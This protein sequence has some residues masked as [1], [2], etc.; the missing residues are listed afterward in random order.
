MKTFAILLT[1]AAV[2][3]AR[4]VPARAQPQQPVRTVS[5]FFRD[6]TAEWMRA[7]P[8]Q[9]AATRY[10]T[11][12]EQDRFEE[13]IA[14]NTPESRRAVIL[15]ARKGLAELATFDRGRM[16]ETERTSADLMQWQLETLVE[17]EKYRDYQFPLEQFGGANVNLPA[18]LTVNHP[19]VTEKDAVH[20]VSRLGQVGARMDEAVAEASG[21]IAKNMIPPRF[22]L[23]ATIVQ[24]RQFIATPPSKNPFVTA[25][26]DRLATAKAV[27]D[28]RREELREQAERIVATQVYPAWKRGIAV[29]EP[30]VGRAKDD[31]GL[32]RFAGGSDAYA[33][34]LRRFTT[35]NLTADEIHKIGL[36]RVAAIEQQMEAILKQLGRTE[37]TLKD[38]IK[39]I[40]KSQAYPLTEEGRRLIMADVERILRD[41]ERRA[42]LQF[43]VRPKAP[44]VAQ[45]YPRFREANAAASYSA[46]APDGS[47]PGTFQIP[48]R[49]ER[50]TK[51][52]LRT[53]VYHETVPGHHF[54]VALEMENPSLPRFRRVRAFGG[55]SAL[56]EGWGLYA[57]RL[58]AE[59]GWYDN[60]LEGQL[61]QLDM[62]L[63]RA[64]RLVVDTGIHAK[65]W[66]RQQAIDYGIEASEVERYVVNPG[67]ACSYMMGELK[68]LELRDKAKKALGDKFS[69]RDFHTAVLSAGTV[70]LELLERRV[71]A[72]LR[73]AAVVSSLPKGES[74]VPVFHEPHHRMLFAAGTTKILEG[75]LPPGDT[76]W[77]HVHTEP[78]LYITLS[79]SQQRTQVL[80]QEM[81][82]GRGAPPAVGRANAPPAPG[83]GGA[84]PNG[85]AIRATSTTSYYDEPVTH[86]ITNVGD[87]LFRFMVV[88]NASPGDEKGTN[89]GAGFPGKAELSN[90][91]F[92]AY[93]QTLAP[94]QVSEPHRHTTEAVIVQVSDGRG[95]AVGPMTWE[96]WEPGRWAW[97]D[98]DKVH[99]IRN[100][101]TVPL[102]YIEVEVRRPDR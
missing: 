37:G 82:A 6:F 8:N 48:L 9:A 38:R 73:V 74:V 33:Y 15:L 57:E 62:E 84:P 30:L 40:E 51:Y 98:A 64:R 59:S 25:F 83:R 91:W 41:A 94:G 39:A 36:E 42:A 66:T 7:N 85:P 3:A 20:Y 68:I 12:A 44:V 46:P 81:N 2:S 67:Q 21:L 92:R 58:A 60:D 26:D 47:R 17:G 13:Q 63:F 45:P 14:P 27:P 71:D 50:M 32:W 1:V 54:Q 53:L 97:F 102:E 10:F 18:I 93:R 88:T 5:D 76:S 11:G 23:R 29:L 80:G 78:I 31:A 16:S 61:G 28:A 34:A 100:T 4:G 79:Q 69:I 56:S 49:P 99:E 52:T 101:G 87:R 24:M 95:V 90:R 35:T 55:I 72:Y 77:Y 89:T 70:P 19:L 22:I 96:F 65:H 86:K 43:D 75:Q